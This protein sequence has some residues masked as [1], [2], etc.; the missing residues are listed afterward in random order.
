MPGLHP[1]KLTTSEEDYLKA[2]YL[3]TEWEDE[4]VGT[5]ALADQLGL[6]PPRPPRWCK[7]LRLKVWSIMFRVAPSR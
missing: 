2:L 4:P 6:S 7:S 3:L 1:H 5:G